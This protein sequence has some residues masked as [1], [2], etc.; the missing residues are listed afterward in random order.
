[1]ARPKE[2]ESEEALKKAI[3]V[4]SASGYEGTSTD[5]LL[6]VMGISRQS[7]YDTYGDKRRL[8]L[9]ALESYTAESVGQQIRHLSSQ[10][11]VLKG[12]EAVVAF[13]VSQAIASSEP[14]CLGISAICE[15]GRSDAEVSMIIDLSSRTLLSA[16]ERRIDEGKAAG[17]IGNAINSKIAAQ[18]V[19]ATLTGIK[20]AA[21]AGGSAESLRGIARMAL[22]AFQ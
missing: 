2:F 22:R 13:T 12:I 9:S 8:Y 19:M 17:E 21:R 7:M 1:M 15:F 4:F 5:E 11:S 10:S 20:L 18:F 3:E 16:L 6:R 14:K